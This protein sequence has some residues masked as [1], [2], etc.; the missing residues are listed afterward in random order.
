MMKE[1]R[2]DIW[3]E[4]CLHKGTRETDDPCNDCLNCPFNVDSTK[5][6]FW[7]EKDDGKHG[8]DN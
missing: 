8:H 7:K 3:C 6:V 4:S 2:F 5:P 1:V